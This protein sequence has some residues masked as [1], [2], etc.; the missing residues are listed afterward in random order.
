MT[1]KRVNF[2]D[3]MKAERDLKVTN[4]P[5]NNGYADW[6]EQRYSKIIGRV[7]ENE[8]DI[9][10]AKS[11][12]MSAKGDVELASKMFLAKNAANVGEVKSSRQ[13]QVQ[14]LSPTAY[15]PTRAHASDAG[16]DL[17]SD[18]DGYLGASG[19]RGLYRT[20]VAVSIPEGYVGLVCPR[21]GLAHQYGVSV[22]NAPGVV[23]AGYTGE[24]MVNLINHSRQTFQV[25]RGLKI[26]QLVIT[27]AYN[28]EVTEVA[29]LDATERGDAGHGSTGA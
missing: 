19:S 16:L 23:D 12:L 15:L 7:P 1:A 5:E 20:G 29:S 9:R 11:Y 26:A 18:E 2:D 3:R 25:E 22:L 14:R 24:V 8:S 17:Y 13:L 21:S 27:R 4:D 6:M 28:F 10:M